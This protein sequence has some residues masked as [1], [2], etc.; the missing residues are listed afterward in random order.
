MVFNRI[1][2][3]NLNYRKGVVWNVKFAAN[4]FSSV[5]LVFG[6][7]VVVNVRVDSVVNHL[8]PFAGIALFFLKSFLNPLP[9]CGQNVV[10]PIQ[11]SIGKPTFPTD[12][13]RIKPAMFSQQDFRIL[14]TPSRE[15]RIK[16]RRALM[17]V[18]DVD[19][20]LFKQIRQ[21]FDA[22]PV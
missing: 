1:K 21:P 19:F 8:N 18:D 13:V 16:I 17:S 14:L 5:V 3:G 4:G 20:V 6:T 2:P 11:K 22:V 15:R 12:N 7:K 10:S 9:D